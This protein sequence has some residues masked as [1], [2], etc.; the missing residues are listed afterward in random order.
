MKE[1]LAQEDLRKD[2]VVFTDEQ[3]LKIA[4]FNANRAMKLSEMTQVK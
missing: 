3:L 1:V 4:I 2:T